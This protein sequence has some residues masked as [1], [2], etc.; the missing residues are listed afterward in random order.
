[1]SYR[2]RADEITVSAPFV[3][4]DLEALKRPKLGGKKPSDDD[5]RA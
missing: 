4:V 5:Y 2:K 1:M 3:R